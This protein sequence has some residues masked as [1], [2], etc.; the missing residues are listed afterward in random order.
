[1]KLVW[2]LLCSLL[3]W[4]CS[5]PSETEENGKKENQTNTSQP[6]KPVNPEDLVEVEGT[7]YTEYYDAAKTKIKFQGEQDENKE[8]HGRWVYYSEAGKEMNISHYK[9]G[10]LHGFMQVKRANGNFYY[11]GDY[12]EGKKVGIW[13]FYDESGKVA[14]EINYDEE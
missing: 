13:K 6:E 10:V 9:H 7:T 2:I 12:K 4:G 3:I 11:L 8:R 14:N 1:M 5:D